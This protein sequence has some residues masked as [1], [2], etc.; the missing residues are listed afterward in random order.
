MRIIH[1]FA[2]DLWQ[3]GTHSKVAACVRNVLVNEWISFKACQIGRP[4]INAS[5]YIGSKAFRVSRGKS[6]ANAILTTSV[7]GYTWKR[8]MHK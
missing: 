5:R 2:E 6:A 7:S 1:S 8:S 4:Y 3:R